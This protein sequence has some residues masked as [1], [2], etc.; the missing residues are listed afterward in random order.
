MKTIIFTLLGFCAGIYVA[1]YYQ[2]YKLNTATDECVQELARS[3]DNV[4]EGLKF[5]GKA[6]EDLVMYGLIESCV[7]N[8][9]GK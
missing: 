2:S 5:E 3:W 7:D 8:K 4:I 9:G 6:T 1:D